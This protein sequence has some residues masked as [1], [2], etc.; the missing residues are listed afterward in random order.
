[1]ARHRMCSSYYCFLLL[2]P[3]LEVFKIFF[4]RFSHGTET[5]KVPSF[6]THI[7]EMISADQ[8]HTAHTES[9]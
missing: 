2:F 5:S 7:F 4:T 9:V 6:Q 8:A 1:M 3:Y